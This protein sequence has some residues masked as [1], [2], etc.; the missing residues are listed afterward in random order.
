V[1]SDSS[2]SS[3][4]VLGLCFETDSSGKSARYPRQHPCASGCRV[5]TAAGS[6]VNGAVAK[7]TA[8]ASLTT[9]MAVV[10][11]GV[12]HVATAGACSRHRARRCQA[13]CVGS[14]CMPPSRRGRSPSQTRP[15]AHN[16]R[17]RRA[18]PRARRRLRTS[19]R[20]RPR[21]PHKTQNRH[22]VPRTQ[23]WPA[24]HGTVLG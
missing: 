7:K 24:R 10:T 9:W 21:N 14:R 11:P 23:L 12:G 13:C 19:C 4:S 18:E 2:S 15:E 22:P 16:Q 3:S 5:C 1:P 6:W 17:P 20:R 8:M